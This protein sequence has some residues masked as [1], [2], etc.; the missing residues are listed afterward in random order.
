MRTSSVA[1]P[2]STCIIPPA[3]AALAPGDTQSSFVSS[4][5]LA[6]TLPC[7]NR[8]SVSTRDICMKPVPCTVTV[9]PPEE[10]PET[11]L[12]LRTVALWY[13]KRTPLV[14]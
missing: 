1:V 3:P 7:E 6:T 9:V 10:G 14:L 8:H 12:R 5:K 11:T 4:M 2:K 13:V